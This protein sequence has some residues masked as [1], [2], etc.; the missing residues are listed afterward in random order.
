MQTISTVRL[1]APT[2]TLSML[3]LILP[4]ITLYSMC[5]FGYLVTIE[6]HHYV[7]LATW[8]DSL[9]IILLTI[10]SDPSSIPSITWW[11]HLICLAWWFPTGHM[12]WL[13][14]RL[15]PSSYLNH[16]CLISSRYLWISISACSLL[17]GTSDAE[18]LL[19]A[20]IISKVVRPVMVELISLAGVLP[21]GLLV[22]G[23]FL[24]VRGLSSMGSA[25][26]VKSIVTNGLGHPCHMWQCFCGHLCRS[27][28][29]IM[30]ISAFS[31]VP[32]G[33]SVVFWCCVLS[34]P[35]RLTWVKFSLGWGMSLGGFSAF[36][37][38]HVVAQVVVRVISEYLMNVQ[39]S[40]RW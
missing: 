23:V 16:C 32:M 20:L 39:K 19:I 22:I 14:L 2:I 11:T 6:V 8:G 34:D 31:K 17:I 29:L 21:L 27:I 33:P 38:V 30:L 35:G 7:L 1:T 18:Q 28:Y 9:L 26:P 13:L 5:H 15:F 37:L 40:L 4:G 12:P 25:S 36:C 3:T 10:E 24:L